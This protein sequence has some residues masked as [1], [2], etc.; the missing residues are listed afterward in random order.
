MK[1]HIVYGADGRIYAASASQNPAR[2]ANVQ[3]V[4]EGEFDVPAKYADTKIHEYIDKLEVDVEARRL[5]EK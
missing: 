4:M 1:V 3:D 5:R 2:P